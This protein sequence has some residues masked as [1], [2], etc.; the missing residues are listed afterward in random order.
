MVHAWVGLD[1]C[2]IVYLNNFRKSQVLIVWNDFLLLLE[3]QTIHL[4][5]LKNVCATDL[6]ITRDNTLSI[7]ATEKA[8]I[9]YIG[10]YNTRDE[11]ESDTMAT[12]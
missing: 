9:E 2:E 7:F 11:R 4:P 5:R 8:L 6:V 10:R 1:E 12:Q 3:D